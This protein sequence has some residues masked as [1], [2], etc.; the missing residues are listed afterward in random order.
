MNCTAFSFVSPVVLD[1]SSSMIAFAI[2]IDRSH[3][4]LLI[5]NSFVSGIS[6]PSKNHSFI[7]ASARATAATPETWLPD[8]P[9]EMLSTYTCILPYHSQMLSSDSP[10]ILFTNSG[11]AWPQLSADF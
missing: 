8:F 4:F 7:R 1:I 5:S 10:A 6:F 11:P 2:S 3:D 9:S